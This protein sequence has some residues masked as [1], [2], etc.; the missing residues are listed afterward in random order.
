LFIISTDLLSQNK[1]DS[2]YQPAEMMEDFDYLHIHLQLNHPGFYKYTGKQT[3]DSIYKITINALKNPMQDVKYR[4]VLRNYLTFTKCG[5]T[6]IVPSGN[7]IKLFNKRK[8]KS[9]PFKVI[10]TNNKIL[11]SENLSNDSNLVKGTEIKAI[12]QNNAS[13]II[14]KI[15][16]IQNADGGLTS[17]KN[18]YGASQFASYYNAFY[19][20]DSIFNLS[21]IKLNGDTQTLVVKEK[22]KVKNKINISKLIINK[23]LYKQPFV[24]FR[25]CG[26][27][28]QTAI[29]KIKGFQIKNARKLYARAFETI[30]NEELKYLIIDLRGNGG[31]NIMDAAELISYISKDTFSYD[32]VR[33][34][35]GLTYKKHASQK[36]VYYFSR[37]M[38][39]IFGNRTAE[40][41][42]FKYHFFYN[43]KSLKKENHF[44]GAI[45]CLIDN[46]SFSAASFVAAYL[47]HK[48]GAILIG[49]ETAGTESGCYAINTPFLK[50]PNTKNYVRIPHY[51][52]KHTLPILDLNRGVF[53]QIET[54]VN[55]Q[56]INSENDEEMD[57]VWK[58]IFKN[59]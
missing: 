18:Y 40:N 16:G 8:H 2:I 55:A 26:S 1:N 39:D 47:K 6:Q 29:L 20:E 17:M 11:I 56:T 44:N 22:P 13:D 51:Q 42:Q 32:F 57:L 4:L 14:E 43:K 53:P 21:C 49:Q 45:F 36:A 38:L 23:T 33:G 54:T 46:G 5:H 48:C 12:N 59:K 52:F 3:W 34:K 58:L 41:D 28:S 31:G 10:I 35:Q 9:V 50:L 7:S 27:D 37:S 24:D 25:I 30:A 15:Y 19:G